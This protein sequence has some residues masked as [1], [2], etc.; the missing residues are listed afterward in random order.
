MRAV[1]IPKPGVVELVEVDEPEMGPEDLLLG[2]RY[3]GLCGSDLNSYRGTFVMVSYPRIPGHEVSA[4][5][6]K[7]GAAVPEHFRPGDAVTVSPY[8]HCRR[9]SACRVGRT[10]CC[11]H[12]ETMG[13]QRDGALLERLSIHHSKVYPSDGLIPEHVALVEPL[14]I[15][16]H[17]VKR[18]RVDENDTVLVLGCGTIGLGIIATAVQR[19]ARVI[20]VDI[21]GSKLEMAEA[22]GAVH[23]VDNSKVDP[24][25]AVRTFTNGE[26]A[27]VVFE[28]VGLPSTY[29]LAVD[30]VA[31]AGRVVYVGYAKQEVCYNSAQFVMKELD[32][33][34]S[35]NAVGVFPEVIRMLKSGEVPV[36]KMITRIYPF[37][38]TEEALKDWNAAPEGIHK[39]LI[40]VNQGGEH[41]HAW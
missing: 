22:F 7:A 3:V 33:L 16:Y 32:I 31:Q 27:S 10:N 14:C 1:L 36:E 6:L 24:L 25:E 38:R 34:G 26:G 30:A 11:L 29:R 41:D 15:G 4:V 20:G 17:A 12:N 13:V 23:T 5:V 39:I 2:I 28:A 40:D 18:G 37:E 8:F 21:A 19:G 35:R 9:C